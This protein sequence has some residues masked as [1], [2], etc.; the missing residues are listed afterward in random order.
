MFGVRPGVQVPRRPQSPMLRRSCSGP[1]TPEYRKPNQVPAWPPPPPVRLSYNGILTPA[2]SLPNRT[3]P[4]INIPTTPSGGLANAKNSETAAIPV[5]Q[6][7][8]D[9]HPSHGEKVEVSGNGNGN[10]KCEAHQGS[11]KEGERLGGTQGLDEK[12]DMT[13]DTSAHAGPAQGASN[14]EPG[15]RKLCRS[16]SSMNADCAPVVPNAI[17]GMNIPRVVAEHK[18]CECEVPDPKGAA[19]H[20]AAHMEAPQESHSEISAASQDEQVRCHLG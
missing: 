12:T 2:G 14:Q 10:G 9:T 1:L 11:N 19:G 13:E 15:S 7:V 3:T 18:D 5:T 17:P 16:S 8:D 20:M 6:T 4:D